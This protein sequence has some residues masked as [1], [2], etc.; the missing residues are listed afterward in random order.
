MKESTAEKQSVKLV[1]HRLLLFKGI[2]L[3]FF[4]IFGL[5]RLSYVSARGWGGGGV[6]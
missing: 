5:N 2:L 4:S 6:T 3:V 1:Q